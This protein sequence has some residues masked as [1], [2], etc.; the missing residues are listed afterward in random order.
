MYCGLLLRLVYLRVKPEKT[1]GLEDPVNDHEG[2]TSFTE[3]VGRQLRGLMTGR[4]GLDRACIWM[5]D[6]LVE[7]DA[8]YAVFF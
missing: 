5:E 4:I 6:D 2:W 1:F 8:L 7:E 3:L